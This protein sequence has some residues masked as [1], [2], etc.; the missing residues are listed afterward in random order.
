[1]MYDTFVNVP[2]G[3]DI[4]IRFHRKHTINSWNYIE[5]SIGECVSVLVSE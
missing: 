4:T 3:T 5:R 2:H 1:M